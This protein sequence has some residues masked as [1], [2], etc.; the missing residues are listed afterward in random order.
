MTC[1]LSSIVGKFE[2]LLASASAFLKSSVREKSGSMIKVQS[3]M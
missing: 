3:V 1:V 2:A